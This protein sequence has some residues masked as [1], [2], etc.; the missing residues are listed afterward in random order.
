MRC[1]LRKHKPNR[2]PRTPFTTQQLPPAG[3]EVLTCP[4]RS[5]REFSSSLHLT[6]DAVKIC[7]QNR[8]PR[9]APAGAEIEKMRMA[10]RPLFGPPTPGS[11]RHAHPHRGG[12][13]ALPFFAAVPKR[14]G[15]VPAGGGGA[16]R[17]RERGPPHGLFAH[18]QLLGAI[19]P[20]L[21]DGPSAPAGVGVRCVKGGAV[22]VFGLVSVDGRQ[23]LVLH[24]KNAERV[25]KP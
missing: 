7:V 12:F 4:S 19:A 16:E 25:L 2:K 20:A 17:Q 8:P 3:E 9:P 6:E 11:P 21:T 10:A 1:N 18:H 5:A 23:L 24:L 14:R 13:A 15:G 22:F